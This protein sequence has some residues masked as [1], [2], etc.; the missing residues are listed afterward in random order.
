MTGAGGERVRSGRSSASMK[1][2]SRKATSTGRQ[3]NGD[4][5]RYRSIRGGHEVH[6]ALHLTSSLPVV[7]DY[8]RRYI[9]LPRDCHARGG[10][11]Q[12]P[13]TRS[14]RLLSIRG[15]FDRVAAMPVRTE[16][17]PHFHSPLEIFLHFVWKKKK[18]TKIIMLFHNSS[19]VSAFVFAP[20]S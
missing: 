7:A 2:C 14:L 3:S 13:I 9:I 5:K 15:S 12:T 19:P 6:G 11:I 10:H 1:G 18:T 8:S 20:I 4:R 17:M 16:P